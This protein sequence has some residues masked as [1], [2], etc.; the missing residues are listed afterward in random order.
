MKTITTTIV[1]KRG[2]DPGMVKKAKAKA[3]VRKSGI[4]SPFKG[5][6]LGELYQVV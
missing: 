2:V 4:A 6:N 1:R 3:M 5:A